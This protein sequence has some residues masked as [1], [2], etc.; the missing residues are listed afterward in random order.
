MKD[1]R[2]LFVCLSYLYY[3]K[4]GDLCINQMS[5]QWLQEGCP[6]YMTVKSETYGITTCPGSVSRNDVVL[7]ITVKLVIYAVTKCLDSG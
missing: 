1:R 2:F 7:I 3:C 6:T 5:R 4:T